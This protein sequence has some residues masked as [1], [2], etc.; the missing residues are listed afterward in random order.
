MPDDVFNLNDGIVTRMPVTR[1]IASRLTGLSEKPITLMTQKAGMIESGIAAAAIS[2]ARQSRRNS[3]HDQDRQDRTLDHR[4][5]G[6]V[7]MYWRC[8]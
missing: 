1:V 7:D 4:A 6:R 3:A 5:H 2:V 8:S